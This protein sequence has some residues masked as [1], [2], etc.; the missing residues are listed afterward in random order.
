MN[1]LLNTFA[2]SIKFSKLV[3]IIKLMKFTKPLATV[4][5]LSLSMVMYGAAYGWVFA[6]ALVGVLMIHEMGHVCALR[7]L[8][9]PAPGPVFIPFV[10]AAIFIKKI[11]DRHQEAVM[12]IWGPLFGI[13]SA[14]VALGL[15]KATASPLFMV[16]AHLAV[17]INL[18]NMIPISPFDGGRITQIA[19]PKFKYIGAGLIGVASIALMQ[20]QIL[21]IWILILDNF[22][23][24][25][26]VRW[27]VAAAFETVM[28]ILML[29]GYSD[30]P[31]W[32]DVIDAGLAALITLCYY[33]ADLNDWKEEIDT[34]P[35]PNGNVRL[36]WLACW[37]AT[38]GIL[39]AIG[40]FT[41]AVPK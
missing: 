7:K 23:F 8:G 28:V 16:A 6:A 33:L 1:R 25:R 35:Y 26:Y 10:G 2:A 38:S 21:L 24:P 39:L 3:P 15:Y 29:T 37:A 13:V 27:V 41:L 14:L 30:Q 32:A 22:K 12:A 36:R 4:A 11:E 19:G 34:R 17:I 18:F 31:F 5:S 20:P 9:L 40:A